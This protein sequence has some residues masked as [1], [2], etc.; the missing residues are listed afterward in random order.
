[1][2]AGFDIAE[3]IRVIKHWR[4]VIILVPLSC[5]LSA[6]VLVFYVLPPMYEASTTLLVG[7]NITSDQQAPLKYDDLVLSRQLVGTYGEIMKSWTVSEEVIRQLGLP[8]SVEQFRRKIQVTSVGETQVMRLGVSDRDPKLAQQMANTTAMVFAQRVPELLKLNNVAILDPA[9]L[10]L[11]PIKPRKASVIALTGTAGLMIALML[12]LAVEYGDTRLRSKGETERALDLPVLGTI[13]KST[14]SAKGNAVTRFLPLIDDPRSPASEAYRILRT[15]VQFHCNQREAR[16]ITVTSPQPAEGKTTVAANLAIT[17]AQTGRQVILVDADLRR[18]ALHKL[19]DLPNNQGLF[20]L[21]SGSSEAP[22]EQL[23]HT[24]VDRLMLLPSGPV[25]TSPAELLENQR[26]NVILDYLR[27][28]SELVIIDTP[29]A[30]VV[31]DAA[32]IS[33][34]SDGV[35][36]VTSGTRQKAA[37][38]ATNALKQVNATI[39]GVILNQAP[40]GADHYDSYYASR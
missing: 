29:P 15:N 17:I 21:L 34:M 25:P 16:V 14:P 5:L 22:E 8:M 37:I 1:M 7:R 10:P 6:A 35:L 11:S 28:I 24:P 38:N 30:T 4:W 9:R 13:P 18:P 20:N 12:V 27:T 26:F 3:T 33:S 23:L 2:G 19:L 40:P 39:I 32:I 36:L 31:T